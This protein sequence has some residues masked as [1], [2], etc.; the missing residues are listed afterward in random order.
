[1]D[2]E[3]QGQKIRQLLDQLSNS[4]TQLTNTCNM[5]ERSPQLY[6]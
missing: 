5:T 3:E 4:T 2:I 1:M 6:I